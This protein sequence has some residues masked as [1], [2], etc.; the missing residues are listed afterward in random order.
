MTKLSSATA[1]AAIRNGLMLV[2]PARQWDAALDGDGGYETMAPRQLSTLARL[3][4]RWTM[5]GESR[6]IERRT[7][8]APEHLRSQTSVAARGRPEFLHAPPAPRR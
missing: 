4:A 3:P 7:R 5:R 2:L 6:G 8:A 1:T